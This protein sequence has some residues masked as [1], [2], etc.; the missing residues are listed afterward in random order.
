MS[1]CQFC[2]NDVKEWDRKTMSHLVIT[3]DE[4]DSIANMFG[5]L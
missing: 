3:K 1:K 2:N 5:N 4:E